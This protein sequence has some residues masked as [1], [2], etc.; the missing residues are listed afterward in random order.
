MNSLIILFT[1]LQRVLLRQD[2]SAV[3]IKQQFFW[4]IN[5][6]ILNFV[7]LKINIIRGFKKHSNDDEQLYNLFHCL[8]YYKFCSAITKIQI[9]SFPP[10]SSEGEKRFVLTLMN[11][12]GKKSKKK[13]KKYERTIAKK[14]C[15]TA[16]LATLFL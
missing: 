2:C 15:V 11:Y 4:N 8:I 3:I 14:S 1:F 9:F 13:R 10:P 5:L 6:Y 12:P 16:F 7:N